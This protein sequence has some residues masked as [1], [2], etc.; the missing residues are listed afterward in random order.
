LYIETY[1]YIS[2]YSGLFFIATFLSSR[3]WINYY[4]IWEFFNYFELRNSSRLFA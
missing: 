4:F 3:S 2:D 1:L